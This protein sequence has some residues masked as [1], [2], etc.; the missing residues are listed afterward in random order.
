[1][2]K[3]T[4]KKIINCLVALAVFIFFSTYYY[5]IVV[6]YPPADISAS[7]IRVHAVIAH[8]FAVNHDNLPPN[9]LYDFLV[10]LVA[11]FSNQLPSYYTASILLLSGAITA[12]FLISY[13]YLIK[14][15]EF[16]RN[17]IIFALAIAMLFAFPLPGLDF[18]QSKVPYFGNLIRVFYLGQLTPNVW[19]NPTVIFVMPFAVLL[20]FKSYELLFEINTQHNKNLL[21]TIALL[22]V[23][24]VL[25]K[26]SFLFTLLPS[27]FILFGYN[28]YF[29]KNGHSRYYQLLPYLLGIVFVAIEYYS[30]YQLNHTNNAGNSIANNDGQ[31]SII[32]APFEV[33][34]GYSSNIFIAAITSLFFPLI[35]LLISKGSPL[36]SKLVLFA[37]VNFIIALGIWVLF[38]E[39]GGRK[40][41]GNFIWQVVITNYLLFFSL[42]LNFMREIELK[43]LSRKNILIIGS[44]FLLHFV[45]GVVYWFKIINS[46]FL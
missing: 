10:A 23:A 5:L 33:W 11:G 25:I 32:I 13:S 24:N 17:V 34:R 44:A 41:H 15:A 35:Y 9:F 7:D 42:L 46:G 45:W 6:S 28:K 14:Y 36:K 20:F 16:K 8:S 27:V 21:I 43:K 22:I 26:P 19:H 39:E 30:I 37:T 31:S 18:F 40:F 1:M 2:F 12:K 38:A 29:L 3:L 4:D